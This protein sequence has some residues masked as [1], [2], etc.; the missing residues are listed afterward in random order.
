MDFF[1]QW[2]FAESFSMEEMAALIGGID[3]GMKDANGMISEFYK[4]EP[5]FSRIQNAVYLGAVSQKSDKF[6]SAT[7]LDG[8]SIDGKI[9]TGWDAPDIRREEVI[10]WLAVIGLKSAYQFDLAAVA[11]SSIANESIHSDIDPLD[12]PPELDAANLAFRAVLNGYGDQSATPRNRLKEYLG[13]HYPDFKPEQV[14]RIATVA[15]PD[16]TTGRKKRGKE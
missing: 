2:D 12:L 10:R 13:N 8:Q 14:E 6:K 7:N 5:I 15:N 1:K 16:K 11:G 3:P 9:G 4:V